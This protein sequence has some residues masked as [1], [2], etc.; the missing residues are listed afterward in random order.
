MYDEINETNHSIMFDRIEAGTYMV[1]AALTEGNLK[2]KNVIVQQNPFISNAISGFA[3]DAV[4]NF[5]N[6]V[7]PA[8]RSSQIAAGQ[9]G[10]GTR[11][12][13]AGGMM[14]MNPIIDNKGKYTT[15]QTEINDNPFVNK[16]KNSGI[17]GV[18]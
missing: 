17:M 11:Y 5:Q 13:A 9:Y 15:P 1:A 2:I 16:A 14:E 10:G 4:S 6:K 7:M 3:D 8:L 12:A 18:L